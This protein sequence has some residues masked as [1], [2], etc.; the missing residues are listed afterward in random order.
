MNGH[1]FSIR[2]ND[3]GYCLKLLGYVFPAK[4]CVYATSCLGYVFPAK[5]D[6]Y[7]KYDFNVLIDL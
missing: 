3:G 4:I 1:V 7:A 2:Y 6:V 5:I